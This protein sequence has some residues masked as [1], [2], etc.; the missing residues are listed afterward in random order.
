[1]EGEKVAALMKDLDFISL[2]NRVALLRE[3]SNAGACLGKWIQGNKIFS[4]K[5]ILGAG[6]LSE[7]KKGYGVE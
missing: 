2:E 3:P 5:T 7:E 6:L 1:M 4:P